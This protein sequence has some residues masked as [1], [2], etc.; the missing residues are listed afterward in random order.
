MRFGTSA[1]SARSWTSVADFHDLEVSPKQVELLAERDLL[2][3]RALDGV[4]EELAQSR[5]HAPHA[6]RVAFHQRRDRVQRIEEKVRVELH[7]QGVE[8]RFGELCTELRGNPQ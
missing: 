5:D 6:A 8:P 1:S 4:S 3:R 2:F 7:A